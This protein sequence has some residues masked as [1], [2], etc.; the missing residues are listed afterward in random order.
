MADQ[1]IRIVD[2]PFVTFT[3]TRGVREKTLVDANQ[4]TN[5]QFHHWID[6]CMNKTYDGAY[7]MT[8]HI[9]IWSSKQFRADAC[10]LLL[11]KNTLTIVNRGTYG[12]PE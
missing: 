7:L 8:D 9:D 3:T 11:K 12:R 6:G 2:L 4:A 10:N 5:E 1:S